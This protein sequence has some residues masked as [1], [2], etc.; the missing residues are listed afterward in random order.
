MQEQIVNFI[1][2]SSR[3]WPGVMSV[4]V[5]LHND[6][7]WCRGISFGHPVLSQR[8]AARFL[9]ENADGFEGVVLVGYGTTALTL[10]QLCREI[11]KPVRLVVDAGDPVVERPESFNNIL[12]MYSG[13]FEEGWTFYKERLTFGIWRPEYSQDALCIA[14]KLGIPVESNT[15]VMQG[16]CFTQVINFQWLWGSTSL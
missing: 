2:L 10:S 5:V 1:D 6:Y 12:L 16:S 8:R 4:G 7:P 3:L 15:E 13:V 11:G 14:S 9:R